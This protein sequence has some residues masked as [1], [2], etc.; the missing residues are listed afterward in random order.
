MRLISAL[1]S[2]GCQKSGA[3]SGF[4]PDSV[5][6]LPSKGKCAQALVVGPYQMRRLTASGKV[7]GS[8][9]GG[10]TSF[11]CN[12]IADIG[13]FHHS[14]RVPPFAIQVVDPMSRITTTTYDARGW[15]EAQTNPLGFTATYTYDNMGHVIEV[16]Q[17]A[18][19]GGGGS[20]GGNTDLAYNSYNLDGTKK[21]GRTYFICNAIVDI[22]FLPA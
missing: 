8:G 12:L 13:V 16:N 7:H 14:R 11:I 21:K 2:V 22:G 5:K 3:L 20:S 15:V 1:A 6:P 9:I 4:Q 10:H 19:S 18:S 17:P